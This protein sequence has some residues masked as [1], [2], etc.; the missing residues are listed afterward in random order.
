M[1]LPDEDFD[2]VVR[3]DPSIKLELIYKKVRSLSLSLL[4]KV[5]GIRSN[6]WLGVERK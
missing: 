5:K 6:N 4:V 1:I 3:A 2:E